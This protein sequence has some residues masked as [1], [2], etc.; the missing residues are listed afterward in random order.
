MGP[1]GAVSG[2]LSGQIVVL[3]KVIVRSLTEDLRDSTGNL[4]WTHSSGK[5][6][7]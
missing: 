3:S 5:Y 1:V 2:R 6:V 7:E 4:P